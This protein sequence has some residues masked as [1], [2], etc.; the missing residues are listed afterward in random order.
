LVTVWRYATI[1]YVAYAVVFVLLRHIY[2]SVARQREDADPNPGIWR[3]ISRYF[4]KTEHGNIYIMLM[5][6]GVTAIVDIINI[7]VF[8]VNFPLKEFSL[9]GFTISMAFI[10]ARKHSDSFEINAQ[11]SVALSMSE[12]LAD[13]G[14]SPREKDVAT[15]LLRGLSV[16]QIAGVLGVRES[17][18]RGYCK[19]L[20]KKLGINSRTELFAQFGVNVGEKHVEQ[21][22]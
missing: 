1:F 16:R 18:A 12:K 6:I 19:T 8:N 22:T 5:I 17:T 9:L 2:R 15:Y 10:L 21:E 14:L 3:G 13:L 4:R 20:Y 11:E 7:T